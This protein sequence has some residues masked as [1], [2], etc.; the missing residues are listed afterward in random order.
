MAKKTNK[1]SHVLNLITNGTPSEPE[2]DNPPDSVPEP[3]D[4][5]EPVP[6]GKQVSDG[7]VAALEAAAAE[8]HAA[9]LRENA[10]ALRESAAAIREAVTLSETG[11]ILPD[12][13]ELPGTKPEPMSESEDSMVKTEQQ[14]ALGADSVSNAESNAVSDTG[15]VNTKDALSDVEEKSTQ[16]G[17]ASAAAD[18]VLKEPQIRPVAPGEKKVIVVN[19]SSENGRISNEILNN[20]TSHMEEEAMAKREV[21]RMVN[22]ME[23]ILSHTNLEKHMKTYGVC[24]CSRCRADVKA[25]I[26]TRLP[27]KYVVV[28]ESS[29]API[30]GYYESKFRVRL[31]TEIIKS[32]MDV[33]DSPRHGSLDSLQYIES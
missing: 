3:A 2:A 10:A 5:P 23:Q 15:T 21:Y 14:K 31:L 19:E 16:Q 12:S 6:S 9:A 26:L 17:E 7:V 8:D 24:T 13:Q 25:L 32:C 29:V 20:L 11:E 33:K 1:T 30:I 18:T 22:V 4:F 28:D 27:A